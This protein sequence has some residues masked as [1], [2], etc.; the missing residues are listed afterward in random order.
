[1]PTYLK[2][3]AVEIPLQV[4]AFNVAAFAIPEAKQKKDTN[5]TSLIDFISI[6]L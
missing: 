3:F 2:P 5:K 4:P 1:V 6:P